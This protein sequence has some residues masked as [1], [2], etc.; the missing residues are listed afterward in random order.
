[1]TNFPNGQLLIREFKTLTEAHQTASSLAE[2][3][4]EQGLDVRLIEVSMTAGGAWVCAWRPSEPPAASRLVGEGLG[5]GIVDVNEALM[6]ALLSITARPDDEIEE[7]L[8]LESPSILEVL[9][10]ARIYLNAGAT[11]HEV[12]VKRAGPSRGAYAFLSSK[13]INLLTDAV[14]FSPLKAVPIK[15]IGD[16]R[17]FFV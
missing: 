4:N 15:L 14:S 5:F 13:N 8:I 2:K 3:S 9:R 11:V 1:M 6:N 17:R 7:I 12:R 16:Y 10:S